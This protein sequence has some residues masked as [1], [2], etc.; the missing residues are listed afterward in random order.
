MQLLIK[1]QESCILNGGITTKF[2]SLDKGARQGDQ[3]LAFFFILA[4]EVSFVFIKSNN[5]I[6]GLDIHGHNFSY[7][8]YADDRSFLSKHKNL[9]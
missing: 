1:N 8:S 7:T 4:L 2:F 5:Y 6:K 9:L 3:I